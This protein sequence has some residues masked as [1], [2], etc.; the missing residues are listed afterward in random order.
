[1]DIRPIRSDDDHRAALQEIERLW[2][3]PDNS[4]END[5]LDV[6][7]TLVEAYEATRWPIGSISPRDILEYAISD[8]GRSQKE[9][10]ALLGSRSQASDLLSGRRKVSL[11]MAQKISA[12]WQIPIQLLVAPYDVSSAA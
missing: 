7:A 5:K 8:M 1:M 12:A 11:E 3:F 6:L 2:E 9:L 10:A 4:P